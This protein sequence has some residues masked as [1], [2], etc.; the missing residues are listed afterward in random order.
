M[1]ASA[2]APSSVRS[3]KLTA[4]SAGRPVTRQA[5]EGVRSTP[6]PSGAGRCT[7]ISPSPVASLARASL[8]KVAR[9]PSSGP[10]PVPV[11]AEIT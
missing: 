7:T 2:M 11:T 1:T 6:T 8:T 3:E 10:S 9:W 5:P 4:R